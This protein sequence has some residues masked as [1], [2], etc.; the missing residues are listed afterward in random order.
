MG[1]L[2]L[3]TQEIGVAYAPNVTVPEV[4]VPLEISSQGVVNKPE[5][6]FTWSLPSTA[7]TI[8]SSLSNE[9]SGCTGLV[10]VDL[11]SVTRVKTCGLQGTFQRCFYLTSVDLS[12]VA[13][14]EESG[15]EYAFRNCTRLTSVNLSSLES[16]GRVSLRSAFQNCT[17]LTTLSFPALT[18]SSFGTY[19]NQFDSMLQGCSGVTVHLPSAIQSTIGNWTSVQNG[20]GGTN[21]TVL[22]DL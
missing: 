22:F 16:I 5:T 21:T 8:N 1:K 2:Y 10:S 17:S 18:T 7:T 4:Y 19:T 13:T 20:F 6:N 12:S 14:V 9:F 3:G 11:S 15:L